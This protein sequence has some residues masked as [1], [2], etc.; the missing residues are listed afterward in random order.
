MFSTALSSENV[1]TIQ[2]FAPGSDTF[3]L[4]STNGGPFAGL[5]LGTLAAD[6]FKVIGAGGSALDASDR[7]LH[8][9]SAGKLY[10]DADGSGAGTAVQFAQITAG[11]VI[12][13]N[14]FAV[15]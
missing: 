14:D 6:S 13:Q 1:D 11:L 7:I 9:R 8:D 5:A 12:D 15:V 10:F 2:D 4:V 3:Q